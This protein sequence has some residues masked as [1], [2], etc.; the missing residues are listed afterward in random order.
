MTFG[1]LRAYASIHYSHVA[2]GDCY[3][4]P[5]FSTAAAAI[6]DK[7]P[8]VPC[9]HLVDPPH[10]SKGVGAM[11]AWLLWML[12]LVA[13][14]AEMPRDAPKPAPLAIAATGECPGEAAVTAALVPLLKVDS[15]R[16]SDGPTRVTDLGDRFEVTA[17][18]QVGMYT[19]A[20]R[21]CSERARVAAVFIALALNPPAFQAR[22]AA[23]LAPPKKEDKREEKRDDRGDLEQDRAAP[24]PVVE[25]PARPDR[26]GVPWLRLLAGGSLEAA[27]QASGRPSTTGALGLDVEAAG[28]LDDLGVAVSVGVR[29][30]TVTTFSSVSVRERRFPFGVAI[31]AQHRLNPSL[32]L[33]AQAGISLAI[34]RLQ[35]ESP[36]GFAPSTRLDLG[37]RAGVALRLP[38][39]S[40]RIAPFAGVSAEYFPRPYRYEVD[41][42]G[43]IGTSA[44][45]WLGLTLG[46]WFQRL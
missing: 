14:P 29:A 37:A 34:L 39:L 17:A 38:A 33:A 41:R 16:P 26:P 22:P 24:A 12:A 19:D 1:L 18:G 40:A 31:V 42:L 11:N 3:K 46:V 13:A 36:G 23:P 25:V 5:D 43:Q 2:A 27:P 6:K 8:C 28:G 21:D 9:G 10:P 35:D 44:P 30:A 4:S 7:H 20:G 32:E 15:V 45:V